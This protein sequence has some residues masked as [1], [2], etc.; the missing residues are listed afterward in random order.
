MQTTGFNVDGK[1]RTMVNNSL[2]SAL[3]VQVRKVASS[4][5]DN[6]S[7]VIFLPPSSGTTPV[8]LVITTDDITD[9]QGFGQHGTYQYD[10]SDN[11]YIDSVTINVRKHQGP[12]Y[13]V[14]GNQI[15]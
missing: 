5:H 10:H 15:L 3:S 7:L 9:V 2:V 12:L 11:S 6:D 13:E 1:R 8:T 4:V 14:N